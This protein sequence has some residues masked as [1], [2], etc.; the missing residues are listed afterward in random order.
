MSDSD[1]ESDAGLGVK[2]RRCVKVITNQD[3]LD[4]VAEFAERLTTPPL[5]QVSQT[6]VLIKEVL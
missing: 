6:P 5:T 2:H 1:A 3:R 4:K